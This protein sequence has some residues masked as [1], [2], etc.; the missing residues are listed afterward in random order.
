MIDPDCFFVCGDVKQSIYQWK[1]SE[2]ELLLELTERPGVHTCHLN[3]NY[4]NGSRILDYAK[5][6]IRSTGEIDDSIPMRDI[7]G[8]VQETYFDPYTIIS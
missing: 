8:A 7:T 3:E 6:I 5:R 2:P 1:G 4:R